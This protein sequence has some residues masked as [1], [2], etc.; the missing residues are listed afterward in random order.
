VLLS[1]GP[2]SAQQASPRADVFEGPALESRRG[3]VRVQLGLLLQGDFKFTV[4]DGEDQDVDPF[5][6]RRVRPT[7]RGQVG[8]HFE[9]FLNPDFSTTSTV[10]VQDLYVDT[11]FAPAFRLRVG[12]EKTPFGLERLQ[13]ALNLLFLE[14][15]MPTAIAPNRDIGIEALGDIHGGVFSY[16][17]AVMN[18]VEDGGS[19]DRHSADGKDV[20][21]RFVVRPFTTRTKHPLRGL[22]LAIA[23]SAGDHARTPLRSFRTQTSLQRYFSYASG[24]V[25]DGARTRYSPQISY[26]HG[27]FGGF[28]E[29]VHSQAPLR[30]AEVRQEIEHQAWQLAGSWVLT[31]EAATDATAGVQPHANFDPKARH[32]GALQVAARYHTLRVDDDAFTLDLAAP[33]SSRKA[34]AWTFGVNWYLTGNVRCT[35]NFERTV[36][37]DRMP[38]ARPPE[39]LLAVRGQ[40]VF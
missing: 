2:A 14:R 1:T 21:G 34:A 8:H 18:G 22:S 29:Y 39:N 30:R 16:L 12:K 25:N 9:F 35:S 24:V 6:L 40:L 10:V 17:A 33:G 15:A 3:D 13:S 20:S 27:R 32:W 38:G 7:V 36:F 31:G 28:G 4:N 26:Y 5:V 23:G 11:V 37:D 19:F